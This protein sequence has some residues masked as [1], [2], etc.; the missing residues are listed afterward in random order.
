MGLVGRKTMGY[1]YP[2]E[3]MIAR[4]QSSKMLK[5]GLML[6]A[7]LLFITGLFFMSDLNTG[8]ASTMVCSQDAVA[9]IQCT[10]R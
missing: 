8:N 2:N 6:A 7:I 5:G 1:V 4:D 10:L 9:G 3:L